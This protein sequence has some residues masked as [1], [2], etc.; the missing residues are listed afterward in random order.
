MAGATSRQGLHASRN[1]AGL[2]LLALA[3][4]V[5]AL[6]VPNRADAQIRSY[7]D[8]VLWQSPDPAT[9]DYFLMASVNGVVGRLAI[10]GNSGHQQSFGGFDV[11]PGPD[12]STWAVYSRCAKQSQSPSSA[13]ICRLFRYSFADHSEKMIKEGGRGGVI[14]GSPSIWG[15]RL[16]YVS[17]NPG[18]TASALYVRSV[19]ANGVHGHRLSQHLPRCWW[20]SQPRHCVQKYLPYLGDVELEGKN[21][22]VSALNDSHL[23]DV[24]LFRIGHR[25]SKLIGR[26][27]GT[28]EKD[29]F[30][31]LALADGNVYFGWSCG[32]MDTGDCEAG[33]GNDG[34]F[35]G[36]SG[37]FA[38][39]LGS[40]RYRWAA[41]GPW[42]FY[43]LAP[44]T[45]GDDTFFYDANADG[46]VESGPLTF[47][48][49]RT[50]ITHLINWRRH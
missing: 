37:I 6:A 39:S 5:A 9:G 44:G 34:P 11:G 46:P 31:G 15:S 26:G 38:Y 3:L 29:D 36:S 24:R 4:V 42:A 23:T 27:Y 45:A 41:L 8:T 49:S 50:P 20:H 18:E 1:L 22:A 14:G 12:G 48:P 28:E 47:K 25:S 7:E 19:T 30:E 2:A 10:P 40:G 16:A 17:T 32:P 21:L 35:M 13:T 43:S 33:V